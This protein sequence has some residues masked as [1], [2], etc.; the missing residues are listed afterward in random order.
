M[1]MAK[2][3]DL[4]MMAVFSCNSWELYMG[5]AIPLTTTAVPFATITNTSYWSFLAFLESCHSGPQWSNLA[6]RDP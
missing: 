6:K 3:D 1:A 4:A 2:E 5:S